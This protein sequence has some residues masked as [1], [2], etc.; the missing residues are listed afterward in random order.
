MPLYG[1][2]RILLITLYGLMKAQ[3]TA[4]IFVTAANTRTKTKIAIMNSESSAFGMLYLTGRQ[5]DYLQ[6]SLGV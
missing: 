1:V 2:I 6:Q 5:E 3:Q 4:Q